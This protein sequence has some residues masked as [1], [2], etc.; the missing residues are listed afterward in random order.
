MAC[1]LLWTSAV[2]VHDSQAYRKMDVTKGA[3]QT[4]LGT[5][6]NI[7][8]IPNWFQPCQCCCS[9]C[10]MCSINLSSQRADIGRKRDTVRILF[11]WILRP[12][13]SFTLIDAQMILA[14]QSGTKQLT[15]CGVRFVQLLFFCYLDLEHR[16][17]SATE[18]SYK[19]RDASRWLYT[20]IYWD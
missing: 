17:N 19:A 16:A 6:R 7:P 11:I 15:F 3:H 14:G 9:L 4:Y 5:E 13:P 10:C 8:V 2:R 18:S 12:L 20:T 1:T